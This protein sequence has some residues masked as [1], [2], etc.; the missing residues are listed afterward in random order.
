MQYHLQGPIWA[1]LLDDG[2]GNQVLWIDDV[3][4]L[5]Q[6]LNARYTAGMWGAELSY[7]YRTHPFR[8]GGILELY[9]G[10]RYLEFNDRFAVDAHSLVVDDED[11][12]LGVPYGLGDCRWENKV[13]NHIVGPQLGFHWFRKTSRWSWSTEGRF[14]AGFN[15]QSVHQ[16]GLLGEGLWPAVVYASALAGE[17]DAELKISN[18]SPTSFNHTRRFSEFSPAA[19]LRV[20]LAYQLTRCV[21]LGVGWTAIWMDGLARSPGLFD[22]QIGQDSVMGIAG[23]NTQ[24]MFVHGANFRVELNRH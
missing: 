14:F 22:Y 1:E 19:E 20:N 23:D 13:E 11:V 7:L 3:E 10:A 4:V 18:M 24:D 16:Q 15:Q 21:S 5:F 9:M 17:V 2:T 6:D 12:L 8:H